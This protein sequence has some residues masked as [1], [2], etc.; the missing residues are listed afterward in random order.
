MKSRNPLI[1][2]R[3]A[4][5]RPA[6]NRPRRKPQ[7]E[8]RVPITVNAKVTFAQL[9]QVLQ[10]IGFSETII[11]KSHVLFAH[12]ASGA[13]VALPIYRANRMVLPHHLISVRV[14]LDA[15]GLMDADD[16]DD[17]VAAAAVKESAS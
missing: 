10:E 15:N 3:V 5:V 14:T 12:Q 8:Y 11:R 2:P 9:R 7:L 17:F 4:Q 1:D 13:E 16:F 6:V